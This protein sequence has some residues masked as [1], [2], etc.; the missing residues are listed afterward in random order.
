MIYTRATEAFI[1]SMNT[2]EYAGMH[3]PL[4]PE[5]PSLWGKAFALRLLKDRNSEVTP[6]MVETVTEFWDVANPPPTSSKKDVFPVQEGATFQLGL[7]DTPLSDPPLH[8]E[9]KMLAPTLQP[10]SSAENYR[11]VLKGNIYFRVRCINILGREEAQKLLHQAEG[12]TTFHTHRMDKS[13]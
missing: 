8:P 5:D 4:Q 11:E 7:F 9:E 1:K 6:Q 12:S 10:Y 13:S 3:Y 2:G